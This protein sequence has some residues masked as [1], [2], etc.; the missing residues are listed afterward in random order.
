MKIILLVSIICLLQINISADQAITC[1][2]GEIVW[3]QRVCTFHDVTFKPNASVTTATNPEDFGASTIEWVW[4]SSSSSVHSIP[5]EVFTKFPN[6]KTFS[7]L[8]QNI[9]EIE[10][11]IFGEAK[12]L[13]EIELDRNELA[14][15]HK[16]TF[17]G[18]FFSFFVKNFLR[19]KRW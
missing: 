2:A 18:E 5:R 10:P 7:A 9:R 8:D 12:N 16:A 3:G 1:E 11:N 14:F 6:L 15:L 19:E 17:K 4:F 13:E